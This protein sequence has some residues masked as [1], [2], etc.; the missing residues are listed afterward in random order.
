[1]GVEGGG[2]AG[3]EGA[4]GSCSRRREGVYGGLS[5][6]PPPAALEA[7]GPVASAWPSR[8][9]S[10]SSFTKPGGCL[11]PALAGPG[12]SQLAGH[13]EALASAASHAHPRAPSDTAS[14]EV[15]GSRAFP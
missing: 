3:R 4:A 11:E 15:W 9:S 8:G 6:V 7:Q 1:M 5:G 13:S 12:S 2:S 14:M 10:S